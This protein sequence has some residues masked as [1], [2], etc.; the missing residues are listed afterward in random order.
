MTEARIQT[1][2][3]GIEYLLLFHGKSGYANTLVLRYPYIACVFMY[4]FCNCSNSLL[5]AH[6]GPKHVG[7]NTL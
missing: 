7:G 3:R 1:H 5:M 6:E 4:S 2:T